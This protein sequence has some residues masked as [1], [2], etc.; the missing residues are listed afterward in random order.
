M[1][2][3]AGTFAAAILAVVAIVG[4]TQLVS[5]FVIE[6]DQEPADARSHWARSHWRRLV[7]AAV[8]LLAA[9]VV[10]SRTLH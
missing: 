7:Y 8:M 3:S 9:G 6:M 2:G 5:R 4:A 10:L 1:G